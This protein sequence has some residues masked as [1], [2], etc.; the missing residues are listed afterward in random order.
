MPSFNFLGGAFSFNGRPSSHLNLKVLSAM[1]NE[2]M[3]TGGLNDV[4]V[5]ILNTYGHLSADKT[6][7]ALK[8]ANYLKAYKVDVCHKIPI[9][10]FQ[11][12]LCTVMNNQLATGGPYAAQMWSDLED[13]YDDVMTNCVAAPKSDIWALFD[14]IASGNMHKACSLAWLICLAFDASHNNLYFGFAVTNHSIG[15]APDMH[16]DTFGPGV[17]PPTPR[18]PGMEARLQALEVTLG[19]PKTEAFF[20]T[21]PGGSHWEVNSG[22]EGRRSQGKG[23]IE[24]TRH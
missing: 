5:E 17:C 22:V 8:H 18:G 3:A 10:S 13:L 6:A 9:H 1:L 19:L 20:E 2:V 11:V 21:D 7:R 24:T 12:A 15:Q 16:Y 4:E 14:A 23:Y